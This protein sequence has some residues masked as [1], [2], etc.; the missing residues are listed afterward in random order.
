ML[1]LLLLSDINVWVVGR[2]S[3]DDGIL[4]GVAVSEVVI[5]V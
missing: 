2:I 1:I 5:K 4:V 3:F